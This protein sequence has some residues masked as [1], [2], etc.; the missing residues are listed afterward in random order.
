MT[1][2]VTKECLKHF[3]LSICNILTPYIQK[4]LTSQ[5]VQFIEY[6][7][8]VVC[9]ETSFYGEQWLSSN[10]QGGMHKSLCGPLYSTYTYLKGTDS[11]KISDIKPSEWDLFSSTISLYLWKSDLT[12]SHYIEHPFCL[13]TKNLPVFL[14][15]FSKIVFQNNIL[16]LILHDLGAELFH[17]Y[18]S[19][20]VLYPYT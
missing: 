14:S 3:L 15:S 6:S 20:A 19:Q 13:L 9:K 10:I 8:D 7:R 2:K 4:A 16:Y 11:L 1:T 12:P 17:H 5:E 18:S